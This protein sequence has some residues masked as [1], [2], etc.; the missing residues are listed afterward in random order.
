MNSRMSSAVSRR[1]RVSSLSRSYGFSMPVTPATDAARMADWTGSPSTS[2]FSSS[3]RA[4]SAASTDSA[5]RPRRHVVDG[6]QRVPERRAD[7]A[8]RGGVGEVALQRG[9]S[10]A[11]WP[12]CPAAR[13]DSSRLA[14]AFSNRIGLTLCG[15]VER[16]RRARHG[17]L[18]EDAARD[19]GP[20]VGGQ[21][22][23]HAVEPGDVGVQLGLPVV[24]LDLRGQRVPGQA[25][26]L[27]E[28]LADRRPVRARDRD[29]VRA[30]RAGRAV[31]LAQ[32]LVAARSGAAGAAAGARGRRAP[33]RASSASPAA[34]A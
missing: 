16:A 31:E 24:R 6:Q 20:H 32:V 11:C 2:Q 9:W 17:D 13:D 19:V 34:R 27:D 33:C 25:Q 10:P 7:V 29:D 8:L 30:V 1:P 4:S 3:S 12:G 23:Q 15:I 14:S 28:R 18:D 22:V 21:V 5:R 26:V